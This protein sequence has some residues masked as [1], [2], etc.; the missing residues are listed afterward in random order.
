MNVV[1]FI[2]FVTKPLRNAENC[3]Q[4]IVLPPL[5]I[6]K[7]ARAVLQL[8]IIILQENTVSLNANIDPD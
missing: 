3:D 1:G 6:S 4:T 8:E 2:Y 5:Y 7:S